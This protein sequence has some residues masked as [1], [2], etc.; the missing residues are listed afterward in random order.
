M[1]TAGNEQRVDV[2]VLTISIIAILIAADRPARVRPQELAPT[3]LRSSEILALPP[4]ALGQH[5]AAVTGG[6]SRRPCRRTPRPG[7]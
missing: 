5:A 6:R 1:D 7:P 3:Q 4:G 2:A